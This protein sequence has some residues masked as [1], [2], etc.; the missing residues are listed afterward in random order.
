MGHYVFVVMD[1]P[2]SNNLTVK[3]EEVAEA[4]ISN[5]IWL[6]RDRG[7]N[8]L[9]LREG[10]KILIYIGGKNKRYFVC[11]FEISG[12]VKKFSANNFEPNNE[13]IVNVAK[14]LG[15]VWMTYFTEIKSVIMF[16]EPIPLNPL[17]ESLNFI[18]NKKYY[19]LNLR[20][21][22]ISIPEN[23]YKLICGDD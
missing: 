7:G 8:V 21:S 1:V 19:G 14:K 15:L 4:L 12:G 5:K 22:A 3:A 11:S 6:F 23:D 17:I 18:R 2:V 9:K 10:D 16:K 13:R 20:V